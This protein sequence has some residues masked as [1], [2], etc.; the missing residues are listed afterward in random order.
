VASHGSSSAAE[1]AINRGGAPAVA[2]TRVWRAPGRGRARQVGA[3]R[4][5]RLLCA[6]KERGGVIID[7]DDAGNRYS[8]SDRI[9]GGVL[10]DWVLI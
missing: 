1:L 4:G 7:E 9:L 6:G 10:Y 5:T 3:A 8:G 2:R